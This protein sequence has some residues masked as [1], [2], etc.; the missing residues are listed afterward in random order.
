VFCSGPSLSI[1]YNSLGS[2]GVSSLMS[3]RIQQQ[4]HQILGFL[5]LLLLGDSIT[6][7]IS[8]LIIVLFKC[9][10]AY[11][12]LGSNASRNL[13]N[14]CRFS[15]FFDYR[16]S[17]YSFMILRISLIFVVTS[18]LLIWVFPSSF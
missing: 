14:S 1:S 11:K 13:S 3:D 15:S 18:P 4:I 7:L 12:F 8:L 9:F 17:K 5:L 6:A 16:F 10:I 2:I